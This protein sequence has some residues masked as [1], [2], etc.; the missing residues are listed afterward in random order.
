MQKH[1]SVKYFAQEICFLQIPYFHFVFVYISIFVFVYTWQ[2][3]LPACN[4]FYPPQL[5]LL[6]Y[7]IGGREVGQVKEAPYKIILN[8]S[9]LVSGDSFPAT[10]LH[11]AA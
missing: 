8:S 4:G 6:M 3:D 11:M 7:V 5:R 1:L 9:D 2:E 10:S